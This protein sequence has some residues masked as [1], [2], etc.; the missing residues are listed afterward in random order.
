MPPE[1]VRP[2]PRIRLRTWIYLIVYAAI[3]VGHFALIQAPGAIARLS[4][5]EVP[6]PTGAE[7]RGLRRL[8]DGHHALAAL[9]EPEGGAL[10]LLDWGRIG[11]VVDGDADLGELRLARTGGA[12]VPQQVQGAAG[13]WRWVE[14]ESADRSSAAWTPPAAPERHPLSAEA[15]WESPQGPVLRE[16]ID[17]QLAERG[18]TRRLSARRLAY[19]SGDVALLRLAFADDPTRLSDDLVLASRAGGRVLELL[20]T[21]PLGI[22]TAST[23]GGFFFTEGLHS[24]LSRIDCEGERCRVSAGI[25]STGGGVIIA[26]DDDPS[27]HLIGLC[28]ADGRLM[29]YGV[30]A[31]DEV[32][33]LAERREEDGCEQLVVLD[34]RR[35]LV[36]GCEGWRAIS[37][38][39]R[40]GWLR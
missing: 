10:W 21:A 23:S 40:G 11:E 39:P 25:L 30:E 13:S 5:A 34:R 2:H 27:G 8:S 6:L 4:S 36:A 22:V 32:R 3:V 7:L 28:T 33:F 16:M 24:R 26:V 9:R 31:A 18:L 1:P 38:R 35:L 14:G 37:L 17:A 12:W 29:L 20:D 19:L 15:L